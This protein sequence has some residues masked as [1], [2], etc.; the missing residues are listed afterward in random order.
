MYTG[1]SLTQRSRRRASTV[2][3]PP[4]CPPGHSKQCR[5]TGC[6]HLLSFV[7]CIR[8]RVAGKDPPD[9]SGRNVCSSG[10]AERPYRGDPVHWASCSSTGCVRSDGPERRVLSGRPLRRQGRSLRS[11][12]QG[13]GR[14]HPPLAPES[15]CCP[16]GPDGEGRAEGQASPKTR[17]ANLYGLVISRNPA[18]LS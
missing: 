10:N 7:A 14:E 9:W 2:P 8:P 4:T 17:A 11:R 5:T 16:S 15:P 1:L 13:D 12:R 18:K 3:R 6:T